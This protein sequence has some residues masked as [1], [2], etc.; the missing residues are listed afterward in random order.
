MAEAGRTLPHFAEPARVYVDLGLVF[1][2][3][4]GRIGSKNNV[5]PKR[6]KGCHI[7]FQGAG[8]FGVIFPR[9]E[10]QRVDEN[11][12]DHGF[13]ALLRQPHQVQ[14][15]RMQGAH[16]HHD[17]AR[18]R[19]ICQGRIEVGS[20]VSHNYRRHVSL[21]SEPVGSSTFSTSSRRCAVS[22][23]IFPVAS[24]RCTVMRA[25]AR[26]PALMS[27]KDASSPPIFA[28]S[29]AWVCTVDTSP[30]ITGPVRACSPPRR[31]PSSAALSRGPK[32][33]PGS[34][35]PILSKVRIAWVAR[36]TKW[37]APCARAA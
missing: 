27:L 14:V 21:P 19:R 22:T 15:A 33:L 8:I 9:T 18:P 30:R 7:A 1:R 20:G 32:T 5:H 3:H 2:V 4:F 37:L 12:H 23:V 6:V 29:R 11:R 17:R 31:V 26:Y 35:I 36:V 25:I 28:S 13:G 34:S 16:R 10:L 24:A